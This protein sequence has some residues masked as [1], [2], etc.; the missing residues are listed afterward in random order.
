M[1]QSDAVVKKKLS[2]DGRIKSKLS[3]GGKTKSKLSKGGKTKSKLSKGGATFVLRRR[4]RATRA[5]PPKLWGGATYVWV[6]GLIID[7]CFA[8]FQPT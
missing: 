6:E 1:L 8:I 4:H 5:A 2:K 7:T 3:K